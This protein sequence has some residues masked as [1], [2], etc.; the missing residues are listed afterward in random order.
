MTPRHARMAGG[1]VWSLAGGQGGDQRSAACTPLVRGRGLQR[2]V[3]P[4]SEERPAEAGR[5]LGAGRR[6]ASRAAPSASHAYSARR[7][8]TELPSS[9][10]IRQGGHPQ[11]APLR[12]E[13]LKGSRFPSRHKPGVLADRGLAEA[14]SSAGGSREAGEPTTDA[15]HHLTRASGRAALRAPRAS[16][17]PAPSAAEWLA[18]QPL[19][20]RRCASAK[21]QGR[22]TVATT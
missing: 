5:I 22:R 18:G 3:N 20:A 17:A 13:V 15:P 21:S 16:S 7:R 9:A 12:A 1:R 11:R 8:A 19:R 10:P 6:R 4:E 2:R 14:T